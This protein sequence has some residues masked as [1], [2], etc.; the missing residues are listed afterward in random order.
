M[1]DLEARQRLHNEVYS[2]VFR[3]KVAAFGIQFTSPEEEALAQATAL[4]LKTASAINR[5]QQQVPQN[6]LRQMMYTGMNKLAGNVLGDS[7]YEQT[8]AAYAVAN[9]PAIASC[10]D[11][12]DI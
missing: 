9:D 10:L 2:R 6:N 4:R 8:Q 5:S 1:N 12:L 7:R 3:D 11:A